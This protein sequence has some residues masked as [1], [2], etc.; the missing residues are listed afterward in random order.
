M[1]QQGPE[2]DEG[3]WQFFTTAAAGL[4]AG[5]GDGFGGHPKHTICT[6]VT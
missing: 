5:Q 1:T 4:E 6:G 3:V 2:V